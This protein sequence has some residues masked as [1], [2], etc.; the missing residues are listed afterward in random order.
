M[1]EPSRDPCQLPDKSATPETSLNQ[2]ALSDEDGN[3]L[4]VIDASYSEKLER[5]RNHAISDLAREKSRA[6]YWRKACREAGGERD[7]AHDLLR[8]IRDPFNAMSRGDVCE[9]INAVLLESEGE[10]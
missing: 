8:M 1:S 5:S 3:E 7:R 6:E 4:M 9:R 10:E 2:Y